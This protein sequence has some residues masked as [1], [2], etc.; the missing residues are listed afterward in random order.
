MKYAVYASYY[1]TVRQVVEA[2]SEEEAKELY[3]GWPSL[4]HQCARELEIRDFTSD[5]G[6]ELI[7]E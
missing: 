7:E 5:I 3:S 1:V 6:A 2:S 4:C